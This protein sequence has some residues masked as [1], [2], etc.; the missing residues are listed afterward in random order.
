MVKNEQAHVN[1]GKMR[2]TGS[3]LLPALAALFLI[4]GCAQIRSVLKYEDPLTAVENNN[5]GVAY[6]REG[7][8]D[9]AVREYKKAI[10]KDSSFTVAMINLANIYSKTEKYNDAEKYYRKAI[11]TDPAN[12]V[13]RNNLANMYMN[14]NMDYEAAISLMTDTKVPD[15]QLPAYFLD[16][17]GELFQLT[18]DTEKAVRNYQLACSNLTED[19]E[20]F[21]ILDMKLKQLQGSGCTPE[22]SL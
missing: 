22:K 12:L 13:A 11:E 19:D 3:F 14:T 2:K 10:K 15:E 17:L 18:G 8:Y 9:L 20:L 5:L 6:E 16:T 1:C 4:T 7:E 21:M